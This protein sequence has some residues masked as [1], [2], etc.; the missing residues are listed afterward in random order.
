MPKL[1]PQPYQAL[2]R[3]F[4]KAGFTVDRMGKNHIIMEKKG[5]LRPVVI[6]LYSAVGRDIIKNNLRTAGI[7]RDEYFELLKDP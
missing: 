3:V 5:V 1:T 7:S 2:V 4:K 6:P